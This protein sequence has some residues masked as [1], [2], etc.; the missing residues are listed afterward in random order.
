MIAMMLYPVA[1]T[2]PL[3]GG[4]LEFSIN[5]N[6]PIIYEVRHF[7][8]SVPVPAKYLK[9]GEKTKSAGFYLS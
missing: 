9:V 6:A 1:P 5:G 4:K 8:T 2:E 7:W 3:N